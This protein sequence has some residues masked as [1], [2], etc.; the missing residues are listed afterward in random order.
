MIGALDN[1]QGLVKVSYHFTG[2]LPHETF[3][4]RGKEM[5]PT[6]AKVRDI[7]LPRPDPAARARRLAAR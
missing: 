3:L 2:E 6:Y 5:A 7:E 4:G 1:D